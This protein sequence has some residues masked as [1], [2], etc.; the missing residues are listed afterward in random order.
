MITFFIVVT[1]EP[2]NITNVQTNY[3]LAGLS[4]QI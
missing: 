3:K 4:G 1:I 2:Q